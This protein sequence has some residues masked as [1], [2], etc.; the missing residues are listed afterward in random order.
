VNEFLGAMSLFDDP[1]LEFTD[2]YVTIKE[3]NN[4]VRYYAAASS[5]LTSV[6]NIKPFPSADITFNLNSGNLSQILKVASV[7]RVQDFSIVGDGK[8]VAILVS[9][10]SNASGN[11][12]DAVIGETDKTFKV[13]FKVENLKMLPG[14][15][16]VAIGAKK[17]SRFSSKTQNL[18]YYVALELDSTFDF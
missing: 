7:L 15:Y 12:F 1:D 13:N 17:I 10:K 18:T 2:K 6:P 3:K 9:D 5:V 8:S 11:T 16:E 14:D 4:S